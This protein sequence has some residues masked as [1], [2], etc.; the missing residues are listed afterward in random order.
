MIISLRRWREWAKF[1]LL[2]FLFTVLL[3]QLMYYLSS[4]FQSQHK[5]KEPLGEAVKVFSQRQEIPKQ[6]TSL[7][8]EIWERVKLFYQIGE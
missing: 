5:E 8:D 3:Y 1:F 7:S 2:F 4:F 6:E